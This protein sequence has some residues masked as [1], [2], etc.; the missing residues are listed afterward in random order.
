MK[1]VVVP[2]DPV[3][4]ARMRR[5][6][7]AGTTPELIVRRIFWNGGVRFRCGA[8]DLPGTPDLAN[9]RRRW[10]IFVHGCFW[11]LH[12]ACKAAT[13]PK[14]NRRFWSQK[15]AAN[16]RRDAAKMRALASVGYRTDVI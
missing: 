3:T 2:V 6:R 11:H 7:R 12:P 9:R 8:R 5:V 4:S 15:L 10:A 14:R 16:R 13:V 1:R